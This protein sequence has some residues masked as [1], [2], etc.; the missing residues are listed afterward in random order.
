MKVRL[1]SMP[2]PAPG[3]SPLYTG[4]VDCVKKTIQHEGVTAFYKV[5]ARAQGGAG[6]GARPLLAASVA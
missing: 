4:M 6:R 5:G 3:Q 1:Q 2:T